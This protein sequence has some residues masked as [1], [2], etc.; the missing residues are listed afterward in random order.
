MSNP[1]K[2]IKDLEAVG[3]ERN[4]A[5]AQVQMVL[6]LIEGQFV[7][8]SDLAIFREHTDRNFAE[9]RESQ[10]RLA[11]QFEKLLEQRLSEHFSKYFAMIEQRFVEIDKK[12]IQFDHRFDKFE[13]RILV[14]LGF[15]LI[16]SLT[17]AVSVLNWMIK[18]H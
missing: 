14:R 16:G 13:L 17:I 8:K 3:F 7:T 10:H 5:E 9:S 18:L 6:D 12:F 11:E 2:Y 1:M 4:Q 15:L